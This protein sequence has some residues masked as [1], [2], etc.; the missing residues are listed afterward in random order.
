MC[1][2]RCPTLCHQAEKSQGGEPCVSPAGRISQNYVA[3]VVGW[4]RGQTNSGP[5][6]AG[7]KTLFGEDKL[8]EFRDAQQ[9]SFSSMEDDDF[10]GSCIKSAVVTHYLL[11]RQRRYEQLLVAG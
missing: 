1:C 10:P 9:V 7:Y 5:W 4:L 8:I 11:R 2:A 3:L 6:L